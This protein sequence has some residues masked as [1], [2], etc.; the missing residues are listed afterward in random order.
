M[1][2]LKPDFL[3]LFQPIS[4]RQRIT[5]IIVLWLMLNVIQL[6][7]HIH[8]AEDYDKCFIFTNVCDW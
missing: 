4:I 1:V 3:Q 5:T 7:T 6:P 2:K 8:T